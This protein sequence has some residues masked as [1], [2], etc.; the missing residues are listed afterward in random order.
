MLPPDH[1]RAQS[2]H[3]ELLVVVYQGGPMLQS[4]NLHFSKIAS[5]QHANWGPDDNFC[6]VL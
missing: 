3:E 2:C 6:M 5:R 4:L 1:D